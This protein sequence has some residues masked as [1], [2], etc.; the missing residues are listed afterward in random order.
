MVETNPEEGDFLTKSIS[1]PC[2]SGAATPTRENISI[3]DLTWNEDR[4]RSVKRKKV[5]TCEY[6]PLDEKDLSNLNAK[7]VTIL[8]KLD[9]ELRELQSVVS[10]NNT[11]REIKDLTGLLFKSNKQYTPPNFKAGII[12]EDLGQRCLRQTY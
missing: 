4:C 5:E 2:H 3:V 11:K 1:S 12:K 10:S 7:C 8:K 9:K 6:D